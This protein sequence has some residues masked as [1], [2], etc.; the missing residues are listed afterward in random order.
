M[1]IQDFDPYDF[2][3]EKIEGISVYYKN[4]PWAPCTHIRFVFSIGAFNDPVGKE[5][6]A[7]FL[8]H[9]IGNG[10]P[11]VPDKKAV[12]EFSRQY[13]LNSRNAM[14]GYNMTVYLSKCLPENFQKVFE[15]MNDYVFNPFLRKEDI[16]HERK[17]ITQEAWGRYKNE[18][19]L[20]Y[21]KECSENIYARHEKSRISSPLGWPKTVA[22]I[23][24]MD[25]AEFHKKNYIKENLS[26]FLVGAIQKTDLSFLSEILKKTP[27]GKKI[28]KNEGIID[29]PKIK[30][31]ER[32]GEE[33]GDPKEQ[34]E[35][36]IFRAIGKISEEETD[37]SVQ[38]K[39][40]L[41][42]VLFERLRVEHSLCYG[43]STYMSSNKNYFEGGVMIN[44][45]EDKLELVEKEVW[46]V[47]NEIINGKWNERFKTM[48]TM[49]LEQIKSKEYLSD[50]IIKNASVDFIYNGK[51][52]TL[53]E[54]VNEAKKV[55]YQDIQKF[56][57]KIFDPEYVFTEVILP[58]KK[59]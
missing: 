21:I 39:M 47:I 51:I 44:T 43:V 34:L 37:I 55:T 46:N 19:H 11:L 25:T 50:D 24:Q 49:A 15:T 58:S 59:V 20:N 22:E 42:D 1:H 9:M 30:R 56:L 23:E 52:K 14:T 33:I 12:K 17:V 38:T 40:L 7:H 45:S 6:L 36:S 48:H 29:K 54:I 18:K 27:S 3:E 28:E 35:F 41:Y 13:M 16:E 2:S 8:E 32:I 53:N 26:I 31:F 10:S 5:G 4:L 57:K